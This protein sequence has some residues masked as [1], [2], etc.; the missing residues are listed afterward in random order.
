MSTDNINITDKASLEPVRHSVEKFDQLDMKETNIP[1][2][3]DVDCQTSTGIDDD[4][5][6]SNSLTYQDGSNRDERSDPSIDEPDSHCKT[7]RDMSNGK[8]LVND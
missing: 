1:G 7:L 6:L 5:A 2:S 8:Q 3:A 4:S